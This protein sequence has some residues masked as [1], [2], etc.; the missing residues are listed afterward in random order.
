MTTDLAA[1][2]PRTLTAREFHELADVPPE[3]EWFANIDNPRTKRAYR[4][5]LEDFMAFTGII[6]PEEFRQVS[7]AHVIAWRKKLE[8]RPRRR[9]HFPLS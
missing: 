1:T 6:Q 7:R 4:I 5:D 9:A 3:M 8:G 2:K